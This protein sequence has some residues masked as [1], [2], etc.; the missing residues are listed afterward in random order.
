MIVDMWWRDFS[1]MVDSIHPNLGT[2]SDKVA[3]KVEMVSEYE[4]NSILELIAQVQ[5][6]VND[7]RQMATDT[8][9][10]S[11]SIYADLEL[12]SANLESFLS[13]MKSWMLRL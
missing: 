8:K 4:G 3:H 2:I 10:E 11:E 13:K 1:A 6:Q 9:K 5:D 12:L 7:S